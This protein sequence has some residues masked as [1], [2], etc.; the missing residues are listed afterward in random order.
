MLSVNSVAQ[1]YP[2]T[3]ANDLGDVSGTVSQNVEAGSYMAATSVGDTDWTFTTPS[4]T[5]GYVTEWT[6]AL[7]DGG[8]FTQ[9]FAG[10]LWPG[11]TVPTFTTNG[12]DILNF[13]RALGITFG[14]RT[15]LNIA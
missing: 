10:V 15:A 2:Q 8:N 6:L 7:S 12:T 13:K 14:I 3:K 4:L 1:Y 9:T 5:S 11:G